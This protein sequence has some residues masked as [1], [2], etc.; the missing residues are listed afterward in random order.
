MN[1]T[2]RLP[3]PLPSLHFRGLGRP[4]PMG[5]I[6]R[7]E[8]ADNY[9]RIWV[10]G[11]ARPLLYGYTLRVMCQRFPFM[12]RVSRSL[13]INPQQVQTTT[14]P[15]LILCNQRPLWL[16]RAYARRLPGELERARQSS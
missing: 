16:S 6:L 12:A 15:Q 7:F 14:N 8:A 9:T 13:A 3:T 1:T 5:Q 10:Q 4:V 2:R 11:Q